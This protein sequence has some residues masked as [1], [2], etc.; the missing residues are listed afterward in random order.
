VSQNWG[1][2]TA[3]TKDEHTILEALRGRP[4]TD[5]PMR[6]ARTESDAG[7]ADII[8]GSIVDRVVAQSRRRG[9]T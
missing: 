1:P 5:G 6:Q 9:T 2:G 4:L 8:T 3:L 7:D